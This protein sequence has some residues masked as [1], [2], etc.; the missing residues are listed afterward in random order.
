ML[1]SILSVFG[2]ALGLILKFVLVIALF[3]VIGYCLVTLMMEPLLWGGLIRIGVI[4]LAA[5]AFWWLVR[6]RPK[7]DE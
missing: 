5:A 3:G 2:G 7:D 1:K 4:I 6:H